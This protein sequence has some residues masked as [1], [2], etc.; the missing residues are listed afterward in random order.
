VANLAR[1]NAVAEQS[2]GFAWRLQTDEGDAA[3]IRP[4]GDAYLVNRS[5]CL[6]IES[7]HRYEYR[8]AHTEVMRR[9]R[10]WFEKMCEIY[11]VLWWVPARHVPSM[12]EARRRLRA[13]QSAGPSSEPY[14]FKH[15]YPAPDT[16]AGAGLAEF[17]DSRPDRIDV[18]R[19]ARHGGS[20][21]GTT[22]R[23]RWHAD[24]V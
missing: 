5:V 17:D 12:L 16:N 6:D 2:T 4:F 19:I 24:G 18:V 14:T 9:R 23:T 7:L 20:W 1:S 3:V 13:L 8:A 22:T 21:R 10:V 15:P 11:P